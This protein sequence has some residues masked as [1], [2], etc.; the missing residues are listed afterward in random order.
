MEP[1]CSK[2]QLLCINCDIKAITGQHYLHEFTYVVPLFSENVFHHFYQ[3]KDN[4]HLF[5]KC[6]LEEIDKINNYLEK[7]NLIKGIS[8]GQLKNLD[9]A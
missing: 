7:M 8:E 4:F 3:L 1:Q 2:K 6:V 5:H 9:L